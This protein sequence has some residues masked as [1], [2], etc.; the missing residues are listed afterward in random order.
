MSQPR[1]TMIKSIFFDFDGVL[2]TEKSGSVTTFLSLSNSTGITQK[3]LSD[4]FSQHNADLIL[5]RTT[6]EQVWLS[7]CAALHRHVDASL[8][9]EAFDSTPINHSML[10]LAKSFK[11]NYVLGI[12]TDN[13]F[14]RMPRLINIHALDSIFAP[15]VISANFGSSKYTSEIFIH[16]LETANCKPSESIF[17]DNTENNLGIAR[18]LG[19]HVIHH[20]DDKNDVDGLS[21]L[22]STRYG[23]TAAGAA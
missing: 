2:T 19:M 22:L 23:V 21:D 20:N 13:S 1:K 8:L 14:D 12:I 6:H 10:E 18:E 3:A 17:I 16:A 9:T 4:A 15:I 7:I 11:P 5:G